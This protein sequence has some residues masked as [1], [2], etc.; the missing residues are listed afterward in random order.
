M[1]FH[2]RMGSSA[3]WSPPLMGDRE[4]KE[5]SE[6]HPQKPGR[7]ESP[8]PCFGFRVRIRVS[9]FERHPKSQVALCLYLSRHCSEVQFGAAEARI[10][11][12]RARS[13]GSGSPAASRPVYH[14]NS[15]RILARVAGMF[16]A[17]M[18]RSPARGRWRWRAPRVAPEWGQIPTLVMG[19]TVNIKAS[20]PPA[21]T[22]PA[23]YRPSAA[24]AFSSSSQSMTYGH[25]LTCMP[26]FSWRAWPHR[27]WPR[28]W[29][30]WPGSCRG[31]EKP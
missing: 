4:E 10:L 8:A 13:I 12:P 11:K 26:H 21:R 16:A 24:C 1:C 23:G 28:H 19:E 25:H 18:K 5:V 29:L 6:G 27:G 3:P 7:D 17:Y 30:S 20:I 14:R 22:A 9:M 2:L 31:A 15:T